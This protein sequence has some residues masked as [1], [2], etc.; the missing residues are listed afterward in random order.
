MLSIFAPIT[1]VPKAIPDNRVFD[2][3]GN[4]FVQELEVAV[5]TQGC[6]IQVTKNDMRKT[7][8]K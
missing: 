5:Q 3:G 7:S 6:C 1:E 2:L 8:L 4:V